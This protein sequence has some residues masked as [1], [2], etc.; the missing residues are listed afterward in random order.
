MED[1]YLDSIRKLFLYYKTLGERTFD[2]LA[3]E[4]LF[5]QFN[6][7]SN[8]IA[9]IVQHLWGNMLSRWTDFLTADGEKP[10][11]NRD[12]EF[13][14]NI[15][16]AAEMRDKWEAGWKVLFEALDQLHKDNLH[17][18]VY[19]RNEGHTVVEALNRQLAHYASHIGQIVYIGRMIKG[20]DWQSLSIPKGASKAFNAEKFAR[21]KRREHFTSTFLDAD[22]KDTPEK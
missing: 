2:Q 18:L 1:N 17:S 15:Q 19:I 8:S 14:P 16:S 22:E 3:P 4:D 7:E 21:E 13:E 11:R 12:A 20:K 9:I 10:W 6:P 5:W